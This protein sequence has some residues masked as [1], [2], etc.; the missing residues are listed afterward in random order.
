MTSFIAANS[1]TGMAKRPAWFWMGCCWCCCCCCDRCCCCCCCSCSCWFWPTSST[2]V[3]GHPYSHPSSHVPVVPRSLEQ[4]TSFGVLVSE[5]G[6]MEIKDGHHTHIY[7]LTY[8]YVYL[9]WYAMCIL[10]IRTCTSLGIYNCYIQYF[11]IYIYI[12]DS[13]PTNKWY[14]NLE[15]PLNIDH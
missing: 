14:L 7:I 5:E 13:S 11:N 1:G 4:A 9:S 15:P 12:H 8:V 3:N 2:V 6:K 10:C